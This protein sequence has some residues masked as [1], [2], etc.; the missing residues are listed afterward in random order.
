MLTRRERLVLLLLA[1]G[2]TYGEIAARL[3][4]SVHTVRTHVKNSYSKLGVH[5]AAAA[6]R[7]AGELGLLPRR[8]RRDKR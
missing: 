4:I 7:R 6:V 1:H 8:Q 5:R 2:C 3:E